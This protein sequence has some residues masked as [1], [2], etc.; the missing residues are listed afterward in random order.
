MRNVNDGLL[1]DRIAI[2]DERAL[3]ECYDRF[4]GIINGLARSALGA[5]AAEEIVQ[6]T[7]LRVWSRASTYV[8]EKG[9]LNAWVMRIARNL[10]I[11]ELRR[12]K[13]RPSA[14]L[15]WESIED[16]EERIASEPDEEVWQTE[17][18]AAVRAAC[19]EL[20]S[21]Q[22]AVIALAYFGG[23]TQSEVTRELGIY[24]SERSK[25]G[26][27]PRSS[28]SGTSWPVGTFGRSRVNDERLQ[29]LL[30]AAALGT[31]DESERAALDKALVEDPSL[32][33]ELDELNETSALLAWGAEPVRTRFEIRQAVLRQARDARVEEPRPAPG[34]R[35]SLS[36]IFAGLSAVAVAAAVVIA[37]LL[38]GRLAEMEGAAVA[39]RE[40]AS[41]Q[42]A[43]LQ[44]LVEDG[45]AGITLSGTENAPDATAFLLMTSDKNV[46]VLICSGLKKL[47]PDR[48]Y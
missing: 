47:S 10:I 41:K 13:S 25:R 38:G 36:L 31:L 46:A 24:P 11:D 18:R 37:V 43:A 48:A 35:N 21:D 39:G 16:T 7:F 1:A 19:D 45:G 23:L 4:A 26:P 27:E 14:R 29:E 3:A 5:A 28:S 40:R 12:R 17:I 6:E 34:W 32:H 20:S 8:P 15:T 33:D 22:K 2:G 44:T 9:S 42:V 30:A